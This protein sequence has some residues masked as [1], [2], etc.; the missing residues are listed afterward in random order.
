[1][2]NYIHRFTIRNEIFLMRINTWNITYHKEREKSPGIIIK[3]PNSWVPS[4]TH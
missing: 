2:H 1:M 3:D 4:Q